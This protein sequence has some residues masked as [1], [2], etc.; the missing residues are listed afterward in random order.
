MR[1]VSRIASH[2]ASADSAAQ[3]TTTS[4]TT[5]ISRPPP[6]TTRAQ[7]LRVA[8]PER[9]GRF[10]VG[11]LG[12]PSSSAARPD[13]G[14]PGVDARA[15]PD[16]EH[17][18]ATRPQDARDL[19]GGAL[20][21]GDEHQ[22]EA[23]D[24]PVDGCVGQR[25]VG[26]VLD[27]ELDAV[28]AERRRRAGGPPRPSRAR[29][30]SRGARRRAGSAAAPGTRSRRARPR[31]RGSAARLR[32][33]AARSSAPRA[34]PLRARTARRWRSQPGRDA[35]PGLDLLRCDVVYAATPLKAGM[36]CSP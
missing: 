21:V 25:Q 8:E 22:P 24:D 18:P 36:M 20:H 1:E 28:E 4:S 10:V 32:D 3:S 31:A 35:A 14:D 13:G 6:S 17:D 34:R 26:S 15:R 16:G 27:R 9:P 30:R 33:R 12:E 29:R 19:G 7:P 5:S 11:R 2:H 23:A